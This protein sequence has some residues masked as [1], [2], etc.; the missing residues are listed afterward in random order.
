[1]EE[2]HLHKNHITVEGGLYLLAEL[3][4]NRSL[5]VLDIYGA[6]SPHHADL[7]MSSTGWDMFF[8]FLGQ[9]CSPLHTLNLGCNTV[10]D[11]QITSLVD[12]LIAMGSLRDLNLR[13]TDISS[14]GWVKFFNLRRP[15]TVLETLE[16]LNMM[17]W[18]NENLLNDEG[19]IAFA[20]SLRGNTSFKTLDSMG[21]NVTEEGGWAALSTALCDKSSI[22]SVCNSNHT[23]SGGVSFGWYGEDPNEVTT[24]LNL[25][26]GENKYEVIRQKLFRYYFSENKNLHEIAN[27]DDEVLPRLLGAI[28]KDA[29]GIQ[30][31]YQIVK[32]VPS[33]FDTKQYKTLSGKRKR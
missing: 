26:R 18:A 5:K 33:L 20:T 15:G 14:S 30:M 19:M 32:I 7:I 25:N 9:S 22:Q 28:A 11:E 16:K 17:S 27:I 10:G 6:V 3:I 2:L 13:D 23:F 31:M 21:F 4:E 24:L 8:D 29:K 12:S 1:M